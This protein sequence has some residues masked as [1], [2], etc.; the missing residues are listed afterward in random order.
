MLKMTAMSSRCLICSGHCDGEL[1]FIIC[2]ALICQ[3]VVDCVCIDLR[4]VENRDKGHFDQHFATPA[5]S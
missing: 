2:C 3:G 4:S 1:S 5:E